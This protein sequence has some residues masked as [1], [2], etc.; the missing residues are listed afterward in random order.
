[1]ISFPLN[2]RI[3]LELSSNCTIACPGC[4]RVL[5][6]ESE[7]SWNHGNIDT[8]DL[9]T[10]LGKTD[11]VS[12]VMGGSYGDSIYHPNVDLVIA[13]CIASLD[14]LKGNLN[15]DTNGSYV[16]QEKWQK[17][18]YAL[19][20]GVNRRRNRVRMTFS[21]DGPPD[22]FTTY[23]VNGDWNSIR[24]GISTVVQPIRKKYKVG[25]KYIIFKYNSSFHDLKMAYDSARVLGIDQ[26]ILVHTDRGPKEMLVKASEFEENLLLLEEY[27]A[28]LHAELGAKSGSLP[29]LL[30]QIHP[31]TRRFDDTGN[32]VVGNLENKAI[33]TKIGNSFDSPKA[34]QKIIK[35]D[36]TKNSMVTFTNQPRPPR[37]VFE[38]EHTLPLC[39]NVE[40]WMNF[41]GSNGTL[42][43]CCFMRS[44]EVDIIEELN[45]SSSDLESMNIKNYTAEEIV[46]GPG[47]A[48]II[49]GFDKVDTCRYHCK[50]PDKSKIDLVTVEH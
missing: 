2:K 18:S 12:I 27:T 40:T 41:I 23:R 28:D 22:N 4:P 45:L 10:F 35:F 44:S 15:I 48:K 1:M 33:K 16:R 30:I 42:W 11:Y 9:I 13:Q 26:F 29:K 6:K 19:N 32:Q 17:I 31:R 39:I 43:P 21:I 47:Y 38:T 36:N 25:W 14:K 7:I 37:E 34:L 3:E 49:N 50:K 20:S 24:M 8:N 5:L 46:A